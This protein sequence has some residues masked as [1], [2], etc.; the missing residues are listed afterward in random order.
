MKICKFCQAEIPDGEDLCPKCGK[1][2]TQEADSVEE[3]AASQE[4]APAEETVSEEKVTPEE[5]TV[6]SREPDAEETTAPAED[7]AQ[8]KPEET[9]TAEIK[10]GIQATPGKIALAVAA[11]VVMLAVVIALILAG[12]RGR[13]TRDDA[14][15]ASTQSTTQPTG[16]ATEETVPATVPPDGNPDDVTCKG[17]YT[18]TDDEAV[19]AADTVVATMGDIQLTNRELQVYYWMEVQSFLGNYGSYASYFGLDY[20]KPLDT[21]LS[22]EGDGTTWQQFFLNAALTNW[23]QIRGMELEAVAA[24]LE[25]DPEDQAYLDGI[26]ANLEEMA[27]NNGVTLEELMRQNIGPGADFDDYVAYEET[28]MRGVP[29]YTRFSENLAPTQQELA[30]FFAEHEDEYTEN[31]ITQDSLFVDVR[32]ILIMPEDGT[33]D[34]DGVTTYSDESWEACQKKAQGVL[35]EWLAGERTEERFAELALSQ[36]QD[37]GSSANGGLYENVYPGQMVTAFNDWCFDEA[38]QTGDYDLVRTDFGY[39]VMYFVASHPQWEYY[40]ESDW[41]NEQTNQMLVKLAQDHPAQ[42]DY[43]KIVLGNV[44]FT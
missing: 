41:K 3:P 23:Q 32:H 30:D 35:D 29:F 20:T 4:S 36:S 40:A 1:P 7:A 16:G 27:A 39:H 44:D 5:E 8:E 22:M 43:S 6:S 34:E 19:S 12:T 15:Q 33:T 42:I 11:I 38:R 18:V 14:L 28:Y 31:G 25:M 9:S 10:T 37:G 26:Q 13:G 2:Y 21:Q 24:G 17:T